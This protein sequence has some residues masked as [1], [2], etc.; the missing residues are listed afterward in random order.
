M[1]RRFFSLLA[2]ICV[3]A[4]LLAGCAT[5]NTEDNTPDDQISDTQY[6]P[7]MS[8]DDVGALGEEDNHTEN[9]VGAEDT[10]TDANDM[11]NSADLIGTVSECSNSGCMISITLFE[12]DVSLS[13]AGG[14]AAIIY[15]DETVFQRG[16]IK[17]DGSNYSLSNCEK[18]DLK[19]NGYIL[20]FGSLQADDTYLAERIIITEFDYS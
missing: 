8:S 10:F 6:T 18:S 2:I 14:N 13:G 9:S 1:N 11:F 19:D 3:G 15:T 5:T 20:F 16:T 4:L 12:G 17:S 7:D